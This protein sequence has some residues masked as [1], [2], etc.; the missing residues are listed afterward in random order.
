MHPN[1]EK[2]VFQL[3]SE[4]GNVPIKVQRWSWHPSTYF[5]VSKIEIKEDYYKKTGKLY[6]RAWGDMY[7]RG[8]LS[9][10]NIELNSAGSYQWRIIK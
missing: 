5:L 8:T 6:G 4:N 1:F 9:Q 7:L 10:K 2:N 3:W